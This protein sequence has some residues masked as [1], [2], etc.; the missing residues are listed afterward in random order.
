MQVIRQKSE[1]LKEKFSLKS[2]SRRSSL[3]I[4]SIFKCLKFLELNL[5]VCSNQEKRDNYEYISYTRVTEVIPCPRIAHELSFQLPVIVLP[6]R[7][8]MIK[9]NARVNLHDM[10]EHQQRL[11]DSVPIYD[12]VDQLSKSLFYQA[13]SHSSSSLSSSASLSSSWFSDDTLDEN[14]YVTDQEE[15][16]SQQN[17]LNEQIKSPPMSPPAS[18][19][20]Y[21]VSSATNSSPSISGS[22]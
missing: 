20:I 3:T 4:K 17:I 16:S 2:K 8:R 18:L 15:S 1:K 21:S 6:K 13:P 7:K 9:Q 19:S 14:D 12:R 11:F 10:N 22:E 5:S